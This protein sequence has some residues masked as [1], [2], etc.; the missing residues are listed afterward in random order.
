MSGLGFSVVSDRRAIALFPCKMALLWLWVAV[1]RFSS[2]LKI[3]Y[4][5]EHTQSVDIRCPLAKS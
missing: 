3:V 5:L 1:R 4:Y 2:D